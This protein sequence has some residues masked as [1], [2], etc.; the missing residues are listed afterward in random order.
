[1][2]EQ[3]K[4]TL[5]LMERLSAGRDWASSQN[6]TYTHVSGVWLSTRFQD[7]G[8]ARHLGPWQQ[9]R[10][11]KALRRMICEKITKQLETKEHK[12]NNKI[13]E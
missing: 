4:L 3:R 8:A 6:C 10:V 7:L 12:S 13:G 11:A 1:M 9:R 2:L 5:V